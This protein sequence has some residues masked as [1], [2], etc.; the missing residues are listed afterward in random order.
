M[1]IKVTSWIWENT[2]QKNTKLLVLL[3][4][5]DA[6]NDDGVCW[7]G[8]A[9]IAHKCRLSI[10][11]TSAVLKELKESGE[12]GIAVHEGEKTTSG[13]TNRYYLNPYREAIGLSKEGLDSTPLKNDDPSD[14]GG[15]DPLDF[16]ARSVIISLKEKDSPSPQNGDGQ[17]PSKAKT[18]KP[19]PPQTTVVHFKDVREHYDSLTQEWD[20][21]RYVYIGRANNRYGLPQSKWH[22]PFIMRDGDDERARVIHEY[23]VFIKAP[24]QIKLYNAIPELRGKTLVDGEPGDGHG[25]VLA[26]LADDPKF[27]PKDAWYEAVFETFKY[28]G[29]RNMDMQKMLRGEATKKGYA[30]YNLDPPLRTPDELLKWRDWWLADHDDLSILEARDKVQS[31]IGTWR[32]DLLNKAVAPKADQPVYHR[33]KAEEPKPTAITPEIEQMIAATKAKL[34]GESE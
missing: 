15:H 28:T 10:N 23:E 31:S 3:A 27:K 9:H 33:A 14:S 6:C 7:P 11:R 8:H 19:D 17:T 12:I 2:E 24:R 30:E 32:N 29:G 4:L 34:K 25:D 26:K 5:A 18:E 13:Y 20:D 16:L 21:D 22:N 1:S